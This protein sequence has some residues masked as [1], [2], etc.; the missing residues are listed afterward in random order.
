MD[1]PLA[2]RVATEGYFVPESQRHHSRTSH[3]YQNIL[4]VQ[5]SVCLIPTAQSRAGSTKEALLS[6]LGQL[7]VL[8]HCFQ[9]GEVNWIL[10]FMRV[11]Y[12]LLC[13]LFLPS[14]MQVGMRLI[15]SCGIL[16]HT[17]CGFGVSPQFPSMRDCVPS[18]PRRF[19]RWDASVFPSW[20]VNWRCC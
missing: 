9:M 4:Y 2:R 11:L 14:A 20:D 6:F 1:T 3:I 13:R 17:L 16:P 15:H 8:S 12:C 10:C 19:C 7:M 18:E 5:L